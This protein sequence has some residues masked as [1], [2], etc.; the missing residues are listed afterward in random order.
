[1][2][3]DLDLSDPTNA[4]IA[5]AVGQAT[6]VDDEPA[7]HIVLSTPPPAVVAAGST[8]GLTVSAEDAS[9]A[10]DPGFGGRV[11]IALAAAPAGGTLGGTLTATAIDGVATF[12]GLTLSQA[13]PGY[14]IVASAAGLGSVTSGPIELNTTTRSDFLV[15][16]TPPRSWRPVPAE[17]D[18]PERLLRRRPRRLRRLRLPA[19]HH[20]RP[21]DRPGHREGV[22]RAGDVPVV[23]DFFGDGRDDFGVHGYQRYIVYNPTTG[24]TLTQPFGGP[25]DVPSSATSSGTAMTTSASLGYRPV[26]HRR[27]RDH[28]MIVQPLGGPEDVPVVGD[29]FGDGHDDLGVYGYGRFLIFDPATRQMIDAAVRR[30]GGRPGR[31]RLLRDGHDDLGVYGYG[32]FIIFDPATHQTLVQ[33]FGG[34]EDVPVVGDFFGDGRDDFGVFGYQRFIVVDPSTHQTITQAFGGPADVPIAESAATILHGGTVQA[35]S[36]DGPSPSSDLAAAQSADEAAAL[37][38]L[39]STDPTLRGNSQASPTKKSATVL[40]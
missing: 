15:L 40:P 20:R 17:H 38:A 2:T 37:A 6:I 18:D 23:G 7:T 28:Q 3:F 21:L 27:P 9:G 1:M 30:A 10:V 22:R 35:E 25:E 11:T 16:S 36:F 34:P 19:V 5:R 24:Q 14:S 32:R 33:A 39:T 29:F 13:G 26:H 12:A 4:V 8:F 31:R